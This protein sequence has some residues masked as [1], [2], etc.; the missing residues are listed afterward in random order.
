MI[1]TRN[2]SSFL[3]ALLFLGLVGCGSDGD[4]PVTTTDGG[5][6]GGGTGD[7]T[8][9]EPPDV[10]LSQLTGTWFGSFDSNGGVRTFEFTVDGSDVSEIK[11]DGTDTKLTGSI[12]KATEIPRAFRISI[13]SSGSLLASGMIVADPTGNYVMY[14]Q[15]PEAAG[16]SFQFGVLQ[17]GATELPTYEQV[18]VNKAWAG[19][20]VSTTTGFSTF[21]RADSSATCA[22]TDPAT[23]PP[24]SQCTATLGSTERTATNVV[25]D[26]PLG[27]WFGELTDDPPPATAPANPAARFFLSADKNFAGAWACHDFLGGFP[28][29]C[30]FSAWTQQ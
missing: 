21:T 13:N 23:T 1:P 30:D 22:A 4:D 3:I 24:S 14:M 12:S 28:D 8:S 18:D 2:F 20:T 16:A 15:K 17:K 27:R 9:N 11:L 26:D 25:L 7:P 29:T 6:D 19:D 10:E 5:G